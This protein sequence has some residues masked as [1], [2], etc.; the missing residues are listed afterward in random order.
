MTPRQN[1]LSL[2]R[3]EPYD[4]LPLDLPMTEPVAREM[5]KQLG[6]RDTVEAFGA[7]YGYVYPMFGD[8]RREW[9][10]A[11]RANGVSF[12]DNARVHGDGHA[13]L[14]PP[15]GTTGKAYH[16][17]EMLH[18]L[19][20]FDRLEDVVALP[21]LDL[22]RQEPFAKLAEQIQGIQSAGLVATISLECTVFEHAWYRRSMERFFEDLAEDNP[23]SSWLLDHFQQKSTVSG[24]AAAKAGID[25]IRLGDDVGTQRG[26]MMSVSMWRELLKPRLAAVIR[27]IKGARPEDPP[28]IQYH[29]DGDIRLILDDLVEVGVDILNPVQPE[30]MPLDEIA[31]VWKDKLAFSGMIGT[32]TTMPFGSPEDVRQAVAKCRSWAQ[33]GARIL[34]APTHVLEPDVPWENIVALAE[35]VKA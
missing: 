9:E 7:D 25:L 23:I 19:S 6:H 16:L 11:Y 28:Y 35:A 12:P 4:F 14:V 2:M 5:E 22:S 27:A 18:P 24:I 3:W 15:A 30:C 10:D 1:F 33:K 29:S 31:A 13:E 8:R 20:G 21:W 17:V 32:Q 34:V 26:M